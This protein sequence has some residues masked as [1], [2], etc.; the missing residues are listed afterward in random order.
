MQVERGNGGSGSGKLAPPLPHA[1]D[2]GISPI[3]VSSPPRALALA[4]KHQLPRRPLAALGIYLMNVVPNARALHSLTVARQDRECDTAEP[5]A[6]KIQRRAPD[7]QRLIQA[8]QQEGASAQETQTMLAAQRERLQSALP[9]HWCGGSRIP[10]RV[11]VVCQNGPWVRP[12]AR[13]PL[14]V[15]RWEPG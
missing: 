15:P 13:D 2:G 4:V 11:R 10:G 9:W 14:G 1:Q 6:M 5:P 7:M 3:R 8:A 12:Q